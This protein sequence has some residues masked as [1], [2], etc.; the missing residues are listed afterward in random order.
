[1]HKQKHLEKNSLI[2]LA[3]FGA[4][5]L[6]FVSLSI[7]GLM[8]NSQGAVD[9]YE[10]LLA[11]D[12][13]GGDVETALNDLRGYIYSHMNTQ[14]GSELGINPPIQLKYTYE[15][16]VAAE[17]ERVSNINSELEPEAIAFCEA[18]NPSGFSGRFRLDC[19]EQ[20]K[21][22]NGA[23]I[24]PIED[25]FYKFDFVPPRWSADLAGFSILLAIAFGISF[26]LQLLLYIR[27]RNKVQY[28]N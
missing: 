7:V 12:K 16:L 28:G 3:V 21:D 26:V 19:I 4:A 18:Q 25:D 22:E 17:E 27:M 8:R 5:T 23:K 9:R 6:L 2:R 15:R 11:V 14:I 10:R 1:M 24:Q 20:Y 13:A